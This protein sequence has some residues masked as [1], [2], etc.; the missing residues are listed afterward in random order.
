MRL[1][2]LAIMAAIPAIPAIAQDLPRGLGHPNDGSHWYDRAC[3][4]D[5][6]CEQLEPGAVTRT[7]TGLVILYRSSRGHVAK[8]FLRWGATGIRPAQD[9]KEHGC[10]YS[11]GRVPCIYL[12]PET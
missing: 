5:R 3:C 11:D 7:A 4:D 6:D 2:I 8:G 12:P 9:G 10:S 1:A